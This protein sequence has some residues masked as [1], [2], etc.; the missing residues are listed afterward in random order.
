MVRRIVVSHSFK[1]C[2]CMQSNEKVIKSIEIV[3][4]NKTLITFVNKSKHKKKT[5]KES[6]CLL[7]WQWIDG[8]QLCGSFENK[9]FVTI[10]N[11]FTITSLAICSMWGPG[12]RFINNA[13][14]WNAHKS[15]TELSFNDKSAIIQRS[16]WLESWKTK[17]KPVTWLTTMP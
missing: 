3:Y 17:A 5:S 10:L 15:W 12:A 14:K 6:Y 4:A 8:H 11:G 1:F 13:L 7:K 2:Q 9:K 16:I